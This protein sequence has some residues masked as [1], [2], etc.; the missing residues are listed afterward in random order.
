LQDVFEE[1]GERGYKQA[2]NFA[3]L[4]TTNAT[5]WWCADMS[6]ARNGCGEKLLLAEIKCCW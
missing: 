4:V 6:S 1:E 3:A 2:G 5:L